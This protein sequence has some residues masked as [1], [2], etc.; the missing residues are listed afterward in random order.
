VISFLA[1]KAPLGLSSCA[2]ALLLAAGN[3]AA[4]AAPPPG[5]PLE[6]VAVTNFTEIQRSKVYSAVRAMSPIVIDG[7]PNEAEW[8]RAPVGGDFYQTDPLNGVPATQETEFRILYDD[9][10]IY[11]AITAFQT[12]PILITELRREFSAND[13]DMVVV[14]FDTFDDDRN[15]FAFQTNPGGAM[16]D[17]QIAAGVANENWDG[18]FDV[19]AQVHPW[20]WTAEFA[21]PFRTL[22]FDDSKPVQSWG[23]NIQR[24]QRHRNEWVQWSPAPRPFRVFEASVAGTLTG[25]E[26]VRQGR[27]LN[28]KPFVLS[29]RQAG[30]VR[31]AGAKSFDG[32]GD[33][34]FGLTSQLTLDLTVNTDFSQVEADEQQVNLT[35]FGLFFPEKREFFLENLGIFDIC[36]NAGGGGG[37]RG[38]DSRCGGERDIV[39]FF[40]RRIGLS[41][42]GQPLKMHG[43]A[44]VTGK[45]GGFDVGLLGMSVGGE[46]GT[47]SSQWS[48]ARLRRDILNNSQVGGFGLYRGDAEDQNHSGGVDGNFNFFQQ[49]LNLSGVVIGSNGQT[50]EGLRPAGSVQIS[51]K[52]PRLNLSSG[53]LS[54]DEDFRNDLGFTPRLGIRKY[55]NGV[56]TTHRFGGRIREISPRVMSR[57]TTDPSNRL[58]SAFDFIGNSLTFRD[59]AEF[60]LF[61]NWY[62]ERLD[63]PFR[64]F[65]TTI[66]PGEYRFAEFN[67]RFSTSRA[68]PVYLSGGYRF[69]DFYD[70]DRREINLSLG[71]RYNAHFQAS[72]SLARNLVDLSGGSFT[73]DLIGVRA[74]AAFSPKMF[75]QGFVQYNTAQETVST[76]LRYRF[77]HQP[78]SDLFLVFNEVR[79]LSGSGDALRIFS[80]KATRLF[81]F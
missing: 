22:R 43:G 40:S 55:L 23:L 63:E 4:Q 12:D 16:R 2:L 77:I 67:S 18:V 44:R 79:P 27:N 51:W 39:P 61:R 5:E 11:V 72:A 56:N 30:D 1:Q 58:V 48:V 25:M 21:I 78:L 14:F 6:P 53:F 68:R 31:I 17:Q 24:L 70:G 69:G 59:G 74:D 7:V 66:A 38:G 29:N 73:T 28:L 3:L 9:D 13:G 8:E 47:L 62:I 45:L 46:E 42:A 20:G 49:R 80:L 19:A 37:P 36:G 10:Q 35:R 64:V 71:Y 76:N 54:I 26:G 57:R 34:K 65:G 60:G 32:G 52:D 81:S 50:G 75:L 15:G 33:L 41:D